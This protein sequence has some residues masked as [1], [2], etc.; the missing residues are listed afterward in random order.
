[1]ERIGLIGLGNIG[2]YY[3]GKLVA[4]GY[5]L[6]VYDLDP[7]RVAA[8]ENI[9]AV[10]RANPAEVARESDVILLSLPASPNV[11]QV[12]SGEQGI[13]KG[14][15]AE[16][17][18]VDTGTTR[19]ETEVLYAAECAALGASY[20]DAPITWR[21]HG[22]IIMVGGEVE[23]FER[24][25]PVLETVGSKVRHVGAIGTGQVLKLANQMILAG[26]LA[27]QAETV[28]FTR[29][30]GLDAALL[31]DYLEFP[32]PA[33]LEGD[34]FH[35]GG[36]LALHYKD[37]IYALDFAHASGAS[38]PILAMVHEI[39]KATHV[40]GEPD[41]LQPGIATYWRILNPKK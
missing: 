11:E 36:Q 25:R 31:R 13:L 38:T 12:M 35:G 40:L 21:S 28:E 16:Q 22:L 39:F 29:Q 10:G 19:P 2:S 20:L 15:R 23:A 33:A 26:Q 24:V 6:S 8:A 17:A 41:W 9:G 3:T 32:V 18:V 5:P 1:M 27:V 37:L 30:A 7:A 14:L 34:D 4:A